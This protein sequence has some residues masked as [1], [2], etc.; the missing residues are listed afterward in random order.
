[1]VI[2]DNESKGNYS[3]ENP[4]KLLTSPL[5]SSLYRW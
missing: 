5:E 2:I 1:M 3:H 4:I